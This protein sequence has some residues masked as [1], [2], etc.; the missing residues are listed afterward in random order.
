MTHNEISQIIIDTSIQIHRRRGPGLLESVY[1]IILAY[2]LRKKGLHVERE[3]PIPVKWDNIEMEVGFRADLIV[4]GLVLVELKS[5]EAISKVFKKVVLTYIRLADKKLGLI[6]NFGEE[7][8]K[9]GISRIVNGLSEE[10][11]A[12]P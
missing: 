8:L 5:V 3:V 9:D 10:P 2:E 12:L 6:L 4:E 11:P 7:L 1:A